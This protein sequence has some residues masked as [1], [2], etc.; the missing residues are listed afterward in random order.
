MRPKSTPYWNGHM[1]T[2]V[3]AAMHFQCAL[4]V[5]GFEVAIVKTFSTWVDEGSKE[6]YQ[7]RMGRNAVSNCSG[8]TADISKI[9]ID[10]GAKPIT[11]KCRRAAAWSLG[12]GG[13][14]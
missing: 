2:S 5:S 6:G 14:S 10:E 11:T 3:Q 12:K 8:Q 1:L 4:S 7:V 13:L 9:A